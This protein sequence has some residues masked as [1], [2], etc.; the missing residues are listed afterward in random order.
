MKTP[1]PCFFVIFFGFMVLCGMTSIGQAEENEKLSSWMISGG[2]GV[3]SAFDGN[4]VPTGVIRSMWEKS[5]KTRIGFELDYTKFKTTAFKVKNV[6][7]KSYGVKFL[8]QHFFR[9]GKISPYLGLG[10]GLSLNELDDKKI[11]R[12]RQNVEVISKYAVGVGADGIVGVEFPFG[13]HV[14]LF[15]EG[16][17]RVA[18]LLTGEER[19][20]GSGTDYDAES[21]G[22]L[23]ALGGIRIRF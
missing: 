2:V 13:P 5:P 11:E 6:Q 12:E 16:K 18:Y 8:W 4:T 21:L 17:V 14:A 15:T 22:G 23:S 7:T 3:F 1:P 9:P 10:V 20:S 19:Q